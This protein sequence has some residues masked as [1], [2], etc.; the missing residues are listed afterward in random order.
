M[1]RVIS[2]LLL[3]TVACSCDSNSYIPEAPKY[4]DSNLWFISDK[5]SNVDVFYVLPTCIFDWEN[6]ETRQIC[7]HYDVYK[8]VMKENFNYSLDLANKIFGE[9]CNFYSP[10]YRQISLDTWTLNEKTVD[11]RSVIAMDDVKNA[12]KYYLNNFNK[13]RHFVLAGY[14]QG[15]KGVVELVKMLDAETLKRM[16]AAYVIG[17]RVTDTDMQ[18]K[19]VKIAQG[20]TDRGVIICYNSVK[21][22]DD[23]WKIVSADNRACINPVNWKTDATPAQLNENITVTLDTEKKLLLVSG[24]DNGGVGIPLLEGVITEGNYHLGELNLYEDC[25]RE[26]VKK[27]IAQ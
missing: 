26:N 22:A 11:E 20:E 23:M 18:N 25:L 10:Y 7:H 17:Y 8:E 21:T 13:G 3:L 2:Y 4:E 6:K 15:G 19:N 1:L 12:F 14:S 9:N 27:R 24:Y 5:D 16:D